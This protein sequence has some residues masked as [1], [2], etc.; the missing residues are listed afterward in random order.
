MTVI[1]NILA[2]ILMHGFGLKIVTRN[3]LTDTRLVTNF[4]VRVNYFP[5]YAPSAKALDIIKFILPCVWVTINGVLIE[6]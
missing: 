6:Y 3:V 4:P 1:I 5:L 2:G